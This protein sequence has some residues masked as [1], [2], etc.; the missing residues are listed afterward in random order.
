MSSLKIVWKI[1]KKIFIKQVISLFLKNKYM[2]FFILGNVLF[3]DSYE[4]SYLS[5][6]FAEADTEK[7]RY[8][9]AKPSPFANCQGEF[10]RLIIIC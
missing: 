9:L 1:K 10:Q 7:H 8:A 4:F 2:Y 5:I 3:W 6:F